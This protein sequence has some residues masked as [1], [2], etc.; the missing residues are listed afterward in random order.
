MC[1]ILLHLS[2][3]HISDTS[4]LKP[5]EKVVAALREVSEPVEAAAILISG[6]IAWSGQATQYKVAT[7]FLNDLRTGVQ[8]ELK[9]DINFIAIPG[10]LGMATP[11]LSSWCKFKLLLLPSLNYVPVQM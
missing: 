8:R 5:A 6:D 4:S 1:L 10:Q 3:L 9:V 7:D 11:I 2:D